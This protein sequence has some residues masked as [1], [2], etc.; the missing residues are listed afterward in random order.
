MVKS[1]SANKSR[2]KPRNELLPA[3]RQRMIK[4]FLVEAGFVSIADLGKKFQVSEMTIRR[5]LEAL[6][7][8]GLIQRT[9]GGAQSTEP[10]FFEMSFQAKSSQH[11]AEKRRIGQA[12]AA[13]IQ[14]GRTILLDSGT[15][16]D[17]ILRNVKDIR[18]TIISNALNIILEAIKH[19]NLEILVAGGML[20]KGLSYTT[21]PQ[22]SDF[23]KTIRADI[24]FMGV[25]GVDV[26]AG[27]TVP[28]LL[29][30][31][32]KRAMAK[33]SQ[34]VIVVTDHS[35]LGRVSTSSIFP[36]DGANLLITGVEADPIIIE[37]LRRHIEVM[38]V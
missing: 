38:Q 10:T 23:M 27:F 30:A 25:E 8:Q 18:A 14:E 6:E 31:D 22:T 2:A 33:A 7:R 17:Q 26:R 11:E 5:D 24:L 20:R 15:T 13:L 28:D 4:D 9:Y 21:G 37:Q 1:G 34:R 29:N 19:P 36:L 12:A 32:N 16:T 3:Q 35:K